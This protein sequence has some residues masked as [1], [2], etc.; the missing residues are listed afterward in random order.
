MVKESQTV[1]DSCNDCLWSR[2]DEALVE[3]L[4]QLLSS[5]TSI[6]IIVHRAERLF[7]LFV[8]VRGLTKHSDTVSDYISTCD[9]V[10]DFTKNQMQHHVR[11]DCA[12]VSEEH[13]Y[14]RRR[15]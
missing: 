9:T 2:V 12:A 5:D 10:P 14:D 15:E 13:R 6:A 8:L 11:C 7:E 1:S 3:T 4:L